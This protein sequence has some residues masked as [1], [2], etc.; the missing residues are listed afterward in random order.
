[1][2]VFRDRVDAGRRLAQKLAYLSGGDV[3]VL[4]LPR[5]GVPVAFEVAAAL[6]APLDIIVVRKLGVPA[7]PEVAM[8]AIA[9]GGTRVL[10]P[11]V[12]GGCRIGDRAFHEVEQHERA[13]LDARVARFRR[14][15]E[16]IDL[17]GRVAVIVDD[18]IATGSTARAGCEVARHLGASKVILAVPVASADGLRNFQAADEVVCLSAVQHLMAVG[19]HYRDFS[20]TTDDEVIVLLDAAS[21]RMKSG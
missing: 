2:I 21:A 15:R 16:R 8:G 10:E 20:A 1:M 19:R 7:Q 9:E 17:R 18:G 14:G 5:G 4:G 6:H 3:V 11:E 12:L 13:E